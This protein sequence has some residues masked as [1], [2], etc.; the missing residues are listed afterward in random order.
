L[1]QFF[2]C[3]VRENCGSWLC[4]APAEVTLPQGRI[5]VAPGVRL[6]RGVA[7]MGVD[8]VKLLEGQLEQQREARR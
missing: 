5:Q 6:L 8:M 4:V 1:P 7:Y 2:K 3:F